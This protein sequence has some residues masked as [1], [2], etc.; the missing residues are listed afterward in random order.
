MPPMCSIITISKSKS[1]RGCR[2]S[3]LPNSTSCIAMEQRS[4][5]PARGITM[6]MLQ[7]VGT[8]ARRVAT[9][10][11]T[12]GTRRLCLMARRF[13]APASWWTVPVASMRRMRTAR[14]MGLRSSRGFA[15]TVPARR[16]WRATRMMWTT[17]CLWSSTIV[18]ALRCGLARTRTSRHI[19]LHT[20]I[21]ATMTGAT[22]TKTTAVSI[23][24]FLLHG[25]W[26]LSWRR[27]MQFVPLRRPSV[28]CPLKW[29]PLL[30]DRQ[31]RCFFLR[32][33]A[34]HSWAAFLRDYPE[35][36]LC[37]ETGGILEPS[38]YSVSTMSAGNLC[39]CFPLRL[40]EG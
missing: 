23:A 18:I 31:S 1:C 3:Q 6:Q 2:S 11:A 7:R 24:S 9:R 40:L 37:S 4:R 15:M 34:P 5:L 27:H 17:T 39:S 32:N 29:V 10:P 33:P 35:H 16:L 8:A 30:S 25:F 12:Y 26:L 19:A 38:V 13:C 22:T 21:P 28:S 20:T 36:R 14:C